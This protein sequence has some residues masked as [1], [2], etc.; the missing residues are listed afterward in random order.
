[1]FQRYT[2]KARRVIFFAR[3]EAGQ[4][5][6][7][8]IETEHL[9]LG[10]LRENRALV[11]RFLGGGET[12]T[13]IRAEVEKHIPPRERIAT[14]VEVPLTEESIKILRL[15]A[16]EADRLGHP[17]VGTEHLL[18]GLLH[19]EG[20]LAAQILQARGLRLAALREEMAKTGS[21]EGIR[22]T[23]KPSETA[24]ATLNSFLAGIKWLK[25]DDLLAFFDETAQ[26][27]DVQGKR[28]NREEIHKNLETLFAPYAKKNAEY[29]IEGT[30]ADS[31]DILIGMV[32]WKN[33][34]LA[35]M[36][37]VWMHR[38]SVVL[39]REGEDWS[40]ALVQVTPVKPS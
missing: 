40:I 36:E 1:M 22:P 10:F 37:R 13:T 27:V 23:P 33:A 20:S 38:M 25:A 15:A 19:V 17:H 16:E 39:V 4:Y 7:P 2:E 8:F 29:L 14:S 31:R 9:L 3:Y 6:S 5:G 28:W 30:L 24:I 11:K 32:L 34:I 26:F 35:S 18:L 12:E 21:V